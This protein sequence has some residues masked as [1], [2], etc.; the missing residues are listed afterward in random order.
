MN[1]ATRKKLFAYAIPVDL[2]VVATGVGLI[3]PSIDPLALIGIFVAAVALSAWKSGWIGAFAA[4]VLSAAILFF[5]FNR[6]VQQEQIGWFGA[7][8]IIVS[9]PLAAWSARVRS[10][11]QGRDEQADA[12]VPMI[13]MPRSV[14]ETA[15]AAIIGASDAAGRETHARTEGERVAAER[16]AIEKKKLEDEFIRA[17]QQIEQELTARFERRR[18]ELQTAYERERVTLKTKF[19]AARL[20]IEAERAELQKQLEEE[21]RRPAVIEK[22]VDEDAIAPRLEHLR[23]EL[24]QQFEREL[25]TSVQ[26][27]LAAQRK[28]LDQDSQREIDK[29]RR[30]A[31]ER[32]AAMRTEI[33][34]LLTKQARAGAEAQQ[35][36]LPRPRPDAPPAQRGVF[37]SFFHRGPKPQR[38]LNSGENTATRRA[39]AVAVAESSAT[40]RAKAAP[41]SERKARVLF[42]ESRRATADTAAPRLRQLG[43]EIVIVERLVDAVDEIYRFRPDIIF[44]D[45]GLSDFEKAYKN[46]ASL[47]RNLPIVLT[48]RNA[49]SIPDV[50]R[51]DVVIRPY[52][53]DEIIDLAH[54]AVNDPQTLLAKQSRPRGE[55]PQAVMPPPK[56]QARENYDIVCYNCRVAFDAV[57][58]DWC[59]CLTRERT[60]VCTNCLTCFCKAA[61]AYKETFWMNAPPRLFERRAAE[62]ERQSLGIAA[63]L[64][65]AEVRR[66]LVMLVEDDE[67][68]QAVMQRVCAN[69]SYGS[70][71]AS[72][73]QD[74]FDL[75]RQYRPNLILADAFL[76]KLDG[77]EMCRLLK[78]DA[79]FADTKMVVM[80]GLYTDMRHKSEAIERF[81]IDDYLAKPVSI[82]DLIN[83]L[84]RHLEGVLDLPAQENLHE[85]HRKEFDAA[86]AAPRKTYEVACFTCGDM[87]DAANAEWCADADS[88]LICEHCGNCFCDAPEYRQRFWADAPAVL[89]E[90]KMIVAMR[91]P[92]TASNPPRDAVN[93]PLIALLENDEAVQLLVKTVVSTLGYGF[94][95]G[96]NAQDAQ[97]LVREYAPDLILADAWTPN[98]D[99]REICRQLKEDPAT[100]QMKTI[101]MTGRYSDR[102]YRH[103]AQS[104]F[105][106]DDCI[107]K[108]LV[109]ADLLAMVKKHLPQEVQAT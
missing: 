54:T 71:S 39:A 88:T 89:F 74:G 29:V 42:L 6:T 97:T 70:V 83:L 80:T 44:L 13:A 66:P 32:I 43:I 60:V 22:H 10:R 47:A 92:A 49:S 7:A 95:A 2:V 72:N 52:D 65:P 55:G 98:V 108:P 77:R 14:E 8:S 28:M 45:A 96:G 38:K 37:S 105:K 68:I 17:R 101:V 90:R 61:P 67:E 81:G 35:Q 41:V 85:L 75:A 86:S 12:Y 57:E 79:A 5:L 104:R 102:T 64:P 53:I 16:F 48:S 62:Q 1:A 34:G 21:R 46:I 15:A 20:E 25:K 33:D 27:E 69:L 56:A 23:A 93:R 73:G 106:V 91:D 9:I 24:Q 103:E 58:A 11:K 87:F 4:M 3:V 94:I 40:R 76:P 26:S 100:A 78:Q 19:D 63:N 18:A 31:D 109:A 107:P 84:Q 59:G 82:T 36:Q 30:A 99:G 50:S 51:A